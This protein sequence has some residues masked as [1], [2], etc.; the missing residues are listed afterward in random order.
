MSDLIERAHDLLVQ[1]TTEQ[2]HHYTANVLRELIAALEASERDSARL[3]F[4]HKTFKVTI[5]YA[6]NWPYIPHDIE[7]F[8][9]KLDAMKA[10][11]E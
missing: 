9:A 3:A 4:I 5:S 2:S 10:D 8:R 1:A 7:S 11:H 6:A